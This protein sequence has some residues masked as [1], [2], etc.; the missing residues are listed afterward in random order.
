MAFWAVMGA[1]A[2]EDNALDGGFADE[3]GFGGALVDAVFQLKETAD[4][5]GVDVV[6][7]GGAAEADGMLEDVDEGEAEAFELGVA[8]AA[9]LTAR[10]DAGAEEGFV[11]VDVADAGEERLIEESGLDGEFAPAKQ[12]GEF[13][14][15]NLEGLGARSGEVCGSREIA[16]LEASETA[17]IDEA[18]LASAGEG[19]A[20]VGVG[21]DGLAGCGDEEA[22]GHAEVHDPLPCH[23][24]GQTFGRGVCYRAEVDDDVFANALDADDHAAFETLGLLCG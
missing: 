16:E 8:E 24:V 5:A 9:C 18:K 17:R 21:S 20:R 22:A 4:T 13:R 2:G 3:A 7:D 19:E 12:R 11:G 1:A 15:R 14:G 23:C 6:G 10:T